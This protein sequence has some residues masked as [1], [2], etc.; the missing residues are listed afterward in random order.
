MF[1]RIFYPQHKNSASEAVRAESMTAC[2]AF[3]AAVFLQGLLPKCLLFFPPCC[4]HVTPPP[5]LSAP[6]LSVGIDGTS[7]VMNS[8]CHLVS[9]GQEFYR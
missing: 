5:P 2:L 3:R 7:F 9:F 4:V 8:A 1:W 6:L